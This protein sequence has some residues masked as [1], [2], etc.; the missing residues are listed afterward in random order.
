MH[1]HTTYH[2]RPQTQLNAEPNIQH[3][4]VKRTRR[5]ARRA[6]RAQHLASPSKGQHAT[7]H[8]SGSWQYAH[9]H[10]S[11]H[12]SHHNFSD[13]QTYYR[14]TQ[15]FTPPTWCIPSRGWR[16]ALHATIPAWTPAAR[17]Y[18]RR[19]HTV[20]QLSDPLKLTL[21]PCLQTSPQSDLAQK[22]PA[23]ARGIH[24]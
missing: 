24:P 3:T 19:Y 2:T 15:A 12:Q 8:T 21:S 18:A 5:A 16:S 1:I 13:R 22:A 4:N 10:S 17:P 7:S 23:S 9:S 20:L 11:I 14:L 6:P